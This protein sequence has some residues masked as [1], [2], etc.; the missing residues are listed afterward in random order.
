MNI[1]AEFSKVQDFRQRGMCTYSLSDILTISLF[2]VLSGADDYPEIV[3]Y[4]ET[5]LSFLQKILPHLKKI[6]THDTFERVFQRIDVSQF[7]SVLLRCSE[8]LFCYEGEY[9]LNIDGKVLRGTAR[10]RSKDGKKARKNDGLCILT[11]WASEQRLVLG[12]H[13]V[14]AKT[15]EKTAIPELIRTLDIKDAIITID[16]VLCTPQLAQLIT[17]KGGHYILSV[18]KNTLEVYEQLEDWLKRTNVAS[19]EHTK[20]VDYNGGR[21]EQRTCTVTHKLELLDSTHAYANCQSV[22]KIDA[23]REYNKGTEIRREEDTRYYISDLN[24]DS[25]HFNDYV[26]GHWGI[27][28]NLHW[29]LDVVF[30]EDNCR[31]KSKNAPQNLNTLRKIALQILRGADGKDSLKVRRKNAGW[32]DDYILNIVEN[33]A[34]KT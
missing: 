9:L 17:A 14:G 11:A 6:P 12:Q 21:I 4:G 27:E 20:T 30:K 28:N 24:T 23:V 25:Q 31:V 19:F 32:D 34:Q 2:A 15:N 29:A 1:P 16:A 33:Y 5:K 13:K 3:K 7:E 18:K 22:F 8:T 10:R 26:R